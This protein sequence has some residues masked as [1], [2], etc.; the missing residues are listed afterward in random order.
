MSV[1]NNYSTKYHQEYQQ[2][3]Q[4]QH[5]YSQYSNGCYQ[6]VEQ[7]QPQ[8]QLTYVSQADQMQQ[9][10]QPARLVSVVF[11]PTPVQASHPT[12]QPAVPLQNQ[13]QLPVSVNCSQPGQLAI[14]PPPHAANET[15]ME[16]IQIFIN[17]EQSTTSSK[18]T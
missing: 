12:L 14:A 9:K 2:V 13:Q 7:P 10:Q 5:Q 15:I 17:W 3:Q 4:V 16:P 8:Q 1:D 11:Q 6:V 18:Y